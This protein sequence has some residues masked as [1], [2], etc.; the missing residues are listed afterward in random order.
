MSTDHDIGYGW[1][2]K[3]ADGER[4]IEVVSISN[5]LDLCT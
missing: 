5:S 1:S 2:H 4:E 3:Q